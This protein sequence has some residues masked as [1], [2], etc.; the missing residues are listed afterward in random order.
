[1][2]RTVP[3]RVSACPVLECG[4]VSVGGGSKPCAPR[5]AA[6]IL[7][8]EGTAQLVAS[9]STFLTRLRAE[10]IQALLYGRILDHLHADD[11]RAVA[12]PG[13]VV[14]R[15]TADVIRDVL[16]EPCG[17]RLTPERD[18]HAIFAVLSKEV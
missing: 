7:A 5:P 17:L 9:R 11:V 1:V 18:E 15:I 12:Y 3:R 16:A 13:L 4:A 8:S 6:R 10:K 14:R 2:G